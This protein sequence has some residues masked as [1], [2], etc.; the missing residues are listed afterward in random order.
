MD[1][2]TTFLAPPR[3]RRGA[4]LFSMLAG[5][6]KKALPFLIRTVTP[7]ATALSRNVLQDVLEGRKLKDSLKY[8]GLTALQSV[9]E[10]ALRRGGKGRIH[11]RTKNKRKKTTRV[12]RKTAGVCYKNDIFSNI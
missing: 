7:E 10:K 1:D 4:G 3:T 6:A 9:A 5:L 11:K 8:R 2:I 12:R